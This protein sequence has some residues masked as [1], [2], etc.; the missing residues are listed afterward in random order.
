MRQVLS[1][2]EPS[3]NIFWVLF[4]VAVL[5][6]T[7]GEA[8]FASR[9]IWHDELYTYYI[10]SSPSAAQFW[11]ALKVDLNPPLSYLAVRGSLKVFGDNPYAL[12]LPSMVAFL[13]G[14]FSVY[15]FVSFR[16]GREFGL[17]GMLALWTTP[18]LMI[19]SEA[20]PYALVFGFWGL[21]L[22]SWQKTLTQKPARWSIPVLFASVLGMMFSHMFSVFYVAPFLAA[23]VFLW[24]QTRKLRLPVWISLSIPYV[25]PFLYLS[26]A[27]NYESGSIPQAFQA[28][29]HKILSFYFE[30]LAG[31]SIALLI[32]IVITLSLLP[33]GLRSVSAAPRNLAPSE[34]CLALVLALLPIY[35]MI[36]LM[37]SHA[38]FFPRYALPAIFGYA[39]VFVA[40]MARTTSGRPMLAIVTSCVLAIF[41]F[42]NTLLDGFLDALHG[43]NPM[44]IHTRPF[45]PCA[46]LKP[47]LPLVAASGLTFVEVD[48]YA[49]AQTRSRL[50]YLTS[51]TFALKY[52]GATIFEG[53]PK[54]K[55]VLP[56]RSTVQPYSEFV[57]HHDRFL[58][59]GSIGYP[60]DWLLDRLVDIGA[61]VNFIGVFPNAYKDWQ[62]FEVS[63]PGA[64]TPETKTGQ[65]VP[66][67]RPSGAPKH[68]QQD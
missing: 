55:K 16:L 34:I 7:L 63:M 53:L 23:E 2:S 40:F 1:C 39:L 8:R 59:I 15:K 41:M 27:R 26:K 12:R 38:G 51:R 60:E 14:S 52:A 24:W 31:P 33:I 45:D 22:L 50:Y 46:T 64:G 4:G 67:T 19:G 49:S 57:T 37:R 30:S 18:Y 5:L 66:P 28:S 29:F 13:I 36:V 62:V 6:Y 21:A 47:D 25:V 17:L 42:Q 3:S 35:Q 61:Q 54:A 32:A 10:A 44:L 48:H 65:D 58:V 20:R 43:R 56:I 68:P 11:E 9:Y